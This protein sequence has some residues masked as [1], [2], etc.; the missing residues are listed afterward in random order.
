MP[1][2]LPPEDCGER[3]PSPPNLIVWL[4][5]LVVTMASGIALTLARWPAGEPTNTA[6]FWIDLFVRPFLVWA[7]AFGVRTLYREQECARIDAENAALSEDRRKAVRFASE[8]LAVLGYA[9]LTG[10]GSSDVSALIRKAD[11]K[12]TSI[13]DDGTQ[14]GRYE[15][16]RLAGDDDDPTRYRAC[17]NELIALVS[18]SV[19]AL[20]LDVPFTVRLHLPEMDDRSAALLGSWE[21]IWKAA[22]LRSAS[23]S[24]VASGRGMMELDEWLDIRGGPMLERCVLYVGVRL[25]DV[26]S[27]SGA[28]AASAILLGWAPLARR[29]AVR[30]MALVHRPVE[31]GAGDIEPAMERASMWGRTTLDA[32]KDVWQI[33]VR[34]VG[35]VRIAKKYS[36]IWPENDSRSAGQGGLRDVTAWLGDVGPASG[37]LAVALAIENALQ[38]R[39]PQ[40][41]ACRESTFRF[42]V[43][44]PDDKTQSQAGAEA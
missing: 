13:P 11:N 6:R 33:G 41:V 10:A 2:E 14:A 38:E 31:S 5:L 36:K 44:Q 42:A 40:L 7:A 4:V 12:D 18:E 26:P 21:A 43:V 1:V 9:Y 3:K 34:G 32:V 30:V 25:R 20:P 17:F 19:R 23:A 28:E 35:K 22:K 16:L 27:D 24:L 8:P 29:Q 37:W 39:S 15:L